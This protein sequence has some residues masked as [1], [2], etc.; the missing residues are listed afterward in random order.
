MAR[1]PF[2]ES[3]LKRRLQVN[4]FFGEP[5]YTPVERGW[6]RPTLEVCGM[7]GGFQGEGFKG[8][9]PARASAKISCRLT[10]DQDPETIVRLIRRHVERLPL[11]GV[12]VSVTPLEGGVGPYAMPIDHPG[13]EAAA[14]VLAELYGKP[15]YFTRC[16]GTIP[17]C[18][19]FLKTLGVY[20]VGFSFSLE[21]ENL[22]GPDEYFRLESLWRG[23]A[24][25][26]RLLD[27]F[28]NTL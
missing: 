19:L 3:A 16:G 10:A 25:Y 24:G 23:Q 9:V 2:D 17:V 5:G 28:A 20:T 8:I 15:P 27:E 18:T 12:K 26:V 6:A 1:P 4:D 14:R 11:T 21:D 7:G 13:V 22:H